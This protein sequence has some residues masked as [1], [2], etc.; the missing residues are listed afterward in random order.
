M[1]QRSTG[2]EPTTR[3]QK[4]SRV[5][6]VAANAK[7]APAERRIPRTWSDERDRKSCRRFLAVDSAAWSIRERKKGARVR[8]RKMVRQIA[9]QA[10]R[11][12]SGNV[13]PTP[14]YA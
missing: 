1:P 12:Y 8:M 5:A 6:I 7:T 4:M 11:T 9:P 10:K 13:M 2:K 14:F 3:I